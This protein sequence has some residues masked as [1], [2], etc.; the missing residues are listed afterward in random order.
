MI[1]STVKGNNLLHLH[2]YQSHEAL[3]ASQTRAR[4]SDTQ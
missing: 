4:A 2:I 1:M 3:G